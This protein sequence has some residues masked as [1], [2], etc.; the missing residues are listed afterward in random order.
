MTDADIIYRWLTQAE[1]DALLAQAFAH[2]AEAMR[3]ASVDA[4]SEVEDRLGRVILDATSQA[5]EADDVIYIKHD[6]LRD[7][8]SAINRVWSINFKP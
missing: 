6:A 1:L 4:I 8:L 2:G 5:T 7:C 3:D